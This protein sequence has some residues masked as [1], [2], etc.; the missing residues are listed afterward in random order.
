MPRVLPTHRV[1]SANAFLQGVTVILALLTPTASV[2]LVIFARTV[3]ASPPS[4]LGVTVTQQLMI[5]TPP[6]QP[7]LNVSSAS[8]SPLVVTVIHLLMIQTASA[9]LVTSART[10]SALPRSH[11]AVTVILPLLIL[12]TSALL[13]SGAWAASARTVL[14]QEDRGLVREEGGTRSRTLPWSLSSTPPNLSSQTRTP[15]ST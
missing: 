15:S 8:A 5:L 9:L 11:Q 2:L 7:P 6:V 1:S 13:T 14:S 12:T 3:P 10:A 4:P